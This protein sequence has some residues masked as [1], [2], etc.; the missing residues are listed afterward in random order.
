M[1]LFEVTDSV[2]SG[3][4]LVLQSGCVGV[5]LG[6]DKPSGITILLPV[7]KSISRWMG[8]PD[9]SEGSFKLHRAA[10]KHA[11]SG[12]TLVKQP[13]SEALVERKALV[14]V[15]CCVDQEL[16]NTRI[17]RARGKR[18]PEHIA[19]FEGPGYTRELFLFEP[20]DALFICWPAA[21]LEVPTG[22]PKRFI[23]SWDGRQLLEEP[24]QRRLP[25]RYA[26]ELTVS[27]RQ[28]TKPQVE[29]ESAAQVLIA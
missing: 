18:P 14:F 20:E 11:P 29:L 25:P 16:G 8:H 24:C 1:W 7:G 28:K 27:E 4:R 21:A 12:R 3:V 26:R 5:P 22:R 13:E 17:D 2:R 19:G 23:I 15:D 9:D 6:I 10:L